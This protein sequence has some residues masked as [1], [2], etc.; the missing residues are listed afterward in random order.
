MQGSQKVIDALNAGLT[1]ELTAINQY[2]V[3]AKMCKNWGLNRLAAY[4]YH[5]SIDE[6]KHAELLI[7]RIL[8]LDGVPEIGRYD[9]IRVGADV[10]E[11]LENDLALEI[12][13][14][15]TYNDGVEVCTAE[16]DAASREI[17]EQII[18]ESEDSID[19]I[20]AQF[21]MIKQMGM[22]NYLLSQVGEEEKG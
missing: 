6:M 13:A 4:L 12:K 18:R 15:K 3:Q 1:I 11:Q 10:K 17:M 19:W 21:E 14:S 8:F 2:L 22:E 16:K 9:V 5:E 7:D 20:E